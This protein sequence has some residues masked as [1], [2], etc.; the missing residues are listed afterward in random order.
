MSQSIRVTAMDAS[1][2][3]LYWRRS[4]VRRLGR[5]LRQVPTRKGAGLRDPSWLGCISRAR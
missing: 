1:S 5:V 3:N 2:G 4:F